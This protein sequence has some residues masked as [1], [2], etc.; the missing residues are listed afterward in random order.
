MREDLAHRLLAATLGTAI[1]GF[2]I[3]IGA[4]RRNVD[5]CAAAGV[6][7]SLGDVAGAIDMDRGHGAEG[8]DQVDNCGCPLDRGAGRSGVCD[9]R[10]DEA[11]LADLSER[12]DEV[13]LARLAAGD[14][15]P[16]AR[17]QQGLADVTADKSV[18][19]EDGD[20]L[21]PALDLGA[22]LAPPA[23]N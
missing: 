13:R 12:L 8:A 15:D 11:V 22:A 21:F 4:D 1:F 9:I 5:E 2:G 3:R 14:A 10:F 19:A 18:A 17:F 16:D 6:S 23:R 7:S 20:Q